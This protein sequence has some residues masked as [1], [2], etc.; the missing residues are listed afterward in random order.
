MISRSFLRLVL[1][2]FLAAGTLGLLSSCQTISAFPALNAQWLTYTGQMHYAGQRSVV[3]DVVVRQSGSNLQ[4]AFSSGPGFPLMR[5]WVGG[6][7]AR[8]EGA[9]ARGSWHGNPGHAPAALRGW[10]KLAPAFAAISPQKPVVNGDG[11]RAEATF[12]GGRLEHLVVRAN[13]S[14]ERFTFHFSK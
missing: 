4:L 11:F 6:D 2:P 3:G 1:L 14:G 8:A 7:Q 9:L 5:L 10:V 12:A 13:A